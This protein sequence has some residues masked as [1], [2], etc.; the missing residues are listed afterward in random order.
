MSYIDGFLIAVPTAN[1]QKF[2][3]H[4][5]GVDSIFVDLGALRVIECWS[6]DVP[7]GKV[8]DFFR[9][10][11]AKED[12]AVVFSWIEWPDKATRDKAM[13]EM[14]EMMQSDDRFNPEINPVPFDGARMIYGG[15]A[16]I[17]ELP[18]AKTNTAVRANNI[19]PYLFF[20]GRCEEAINFYKEKLG[21]EVLV[22]MHYRDNPEKD[23]SFGQFPDSLDDKIM[24]ATLSFGGAQI[25]MSDGVKQG[26]LD[27]ACMSISLSVESEAEADRYFNALAKD[28]E[29]QMPIGKTF[30]SPRFGAVVDQFGVSWMIMVEDK[31]MQSS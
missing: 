29:I 11:Q 26:A 24:H 31:E 15:F 2:I 19:E 30:F 21:A 1:R 25:M 16:P 27:F 7:H 18:A 17:F 28:G 22:M 3:D 23:A 20:R 5:N 10:V 14:D 13:A 8:T 9:A 12:E 4:A 6:D